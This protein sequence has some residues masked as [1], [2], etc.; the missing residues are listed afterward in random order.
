MKYC[1]KRCSQICQP[2]ANFRN[3]PVRWHFAGNTFCKKQFVGCS[4]LHFL[5]LLQTMKFFEDPKI[6]QIHENFI[7]A[8]FKLWGALLDHFK[9]ISIWVPLW[10]YRL[11]LAIVW[12]H[13]TYPDHMRKKKDAEKNVFY[14]YQNWQR[15]VQFKDDF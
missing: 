14:K 11:R 12:H 10:L 3:F 1:S 5:E 13:I 7:W 9:T 4:S 2:C 6:F 15:D 8:R